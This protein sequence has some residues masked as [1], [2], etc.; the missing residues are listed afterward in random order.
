MVWQDGN[1]I[2]RGVRTYTLL[3][4]SNGIT[5][6]KMSEVFTGLMLPMIS[7]SLPDFRPSFEQLALDLKNAAEK[8]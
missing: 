1:A 6:F 4:K 8:K 2:F 7:G 3:E 5:E